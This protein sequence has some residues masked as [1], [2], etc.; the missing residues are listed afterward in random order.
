MKTFIILTLN[1]LLAIATY[2][3]SAPH[4]QQIERFKAQKVAFLT[5]RIGLNSA[6]AQKFWPIYN[7]FS[8]KLDSLIFVRSQARNK[9]IIEEKKLTEKQILELL[10]IQIECQWN[11]AKLGRTYHEKF[12]QVLTTDQL[13]R[14]YEA[15]HEFRMRLIKQIRGFKTKQ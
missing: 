2:G 10:D 6:T 12:K 13:K 8:E 11:E 14:F 4:N 1:L 3:Q 9:L 15:E 5:E 7:E